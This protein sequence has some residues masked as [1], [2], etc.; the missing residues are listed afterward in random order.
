MAGPFDS[1]VD[2]ARA[3]FDRRPSQPLRQAWQDLDLAA[4]RADLIARLLQAGIEDGAI[5][6]RFLLQ[7]ALAPMPLEAALAGRELVSWQQISDLADLA[8]QRLQRIPLSQ[9]LGSQPFWTLDLKVTGDVLTPRA[10]TE[11]LVE[12]VLARCDNTAL[13]ML[14]LGTGSGAIL[15]ALLSER[16]GWTGQGIDLSPAALAV[17]QHNLEA[18]GLGGRATLVLGRWGAALDDHAFDLVVSNPPYIVRDIL[19]GLEPEVR[20]HEPALALD[21]GE[22]GLDAYRAIIADLPRLLRPGGRFALEIG[23]DQAASVMALAE[24][25]GLVAL[26]CLPDLAGHD[27]VV[28]GRSGS[29]NG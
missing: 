13:H 22:D 17:A 2:R 19:A 29:D 1:L 26:E 18:C 25:A 24:T 23:F 28:L 12:A 27:R 14:D 8:W 7:R 15:L 11:A 5:E 20:D 16:P 4:V 9:V 3:D 6:S 10:D 21:G